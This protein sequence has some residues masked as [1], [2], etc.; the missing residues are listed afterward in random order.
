MYTVYE[1]QNTNAINFHFYFE[2]NISLPLNQNGS[3]KYPLTENVIKRERGKRHSITSIIYFV[4]FSRI[5]FS[6][7]LGDLILF[8]FF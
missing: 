6:F 3:Q 4:L 5:Y 7:F 8:N 2:Q 1:S